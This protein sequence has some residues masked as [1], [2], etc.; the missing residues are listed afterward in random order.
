[1][2]DAAKAAAAAKRRT[3]AKDTTN[4][5][6]TGSTDNDAIM[7]DQRPNK[8]SAETERP[9]EIP[10]EDKTNT[11]AMD[12]SDNYNTNGTVDN[13]S[14]N[15]KTHAMDT[16]D[17]TTNGMD[18]T[19]ISGNN[20]TTDNIN[21]TNNVNGTTDDNDMVAVDDDDDDDD[22]DIFGDDDTDKKTPEKSPSSSL[23]VMTHSK[24]LRQPLRTTND[25]TFPTNSIQRTAI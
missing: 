15:D 12:T 19:N 13:I 22:D 8:R 23:Q 16:S 5:T 20:I 4:T 9:E 1:V 25:S 24:T 18:N 6:H 3:T 7:H 2:A 14:G 10:D 21:A 17:N 11:E